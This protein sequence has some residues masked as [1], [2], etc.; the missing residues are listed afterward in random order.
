M[1]VCVLRK[2]IVSKGE[3][4]SRF[5]PCKPLPRCVTKVAF[6]PKPQRVFCEPKLQFDTKSASPHS[7]HTKLV[8]LGK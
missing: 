2:E 3:T 4:D 8:P 7:K 1:C 6:M 5:P